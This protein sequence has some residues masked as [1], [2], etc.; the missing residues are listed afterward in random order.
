MHNTYIHMKNCMIKIYIELQSKNGFQKEKMKKRKK[1]KKINKQL[2]TD[3]NI[4]IK[5]CSIIF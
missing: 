1:E 4:K 5:S 3:D 2:N